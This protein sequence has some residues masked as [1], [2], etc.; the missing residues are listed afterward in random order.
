MVLKVLISQKYTYIQKITIFLCQN[1]YIGVYP[2]NDEKKQIYVST[3]KTLKG[4][5]LLESSISNL[6]LHIKRSKRRK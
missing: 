6:Y 4:E 2:L 1:V 5:R 3:L